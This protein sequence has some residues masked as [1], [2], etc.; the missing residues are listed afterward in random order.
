MKPIQALEAGTACLTAAIT[1]VRHQSDAATVQV[2]E[3]Q[4][5]LNF[6]SAH[7]STLYHEQAAATPYQ[8]PAWLAAHAEQLPSTASPLILVVESSAGIAAALSLVRDDQDG[9]R[10]QV[11]PLSAPMAEYVRA[12]GA[13][14][15]APAVAAAL[16]QGLTD[17][18]RDA[19]VVMPD[20]PTLSSLGTQLAADPNWR[21]S[22]TRCATL[23]LPVDYTTMS[24]ATRRDHARRQRTWDELAA[25]QSVVY[26]RTISTPELLEAHRVLSQLHA[27][28]W[29]DHAPRP[30]ADASGDE[31]TERLWGAVLERCGPASAFIATLAVDER[32]VAAQLCLYRGRHCF[33]VVPAMDPDHYQ[34]APGHALLRYLTAD[35]ASDGFL[36]LDLGRTTPTPGQIAYKSQYQPMWTAT[37]SA[38]PAP[39]LPDA[40]PALLSRGNVS[41]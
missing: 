19:D 2:L 35:L 25:S 17:L 20:I 32:V 41:E 24:R 7:W 12:V 18:S 9:G 3:G 8:A 26:R 37:L 4:P 30:E 15:E 27:R 1:S 22:T 6:L 5:A 33:S 28:R 11:R 14:A 23:P 13:N 29:A 10:P 38:K 31:D 16:A 39:A 36:T 34:L 40:T 21:H